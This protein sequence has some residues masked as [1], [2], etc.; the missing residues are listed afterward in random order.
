MN[1]FFVPPSAL[2]SDSVVFSGDQLHQLTRVLRL[3]AGDRV[4]VLTGDGY[5]SEVLLESVDRQ[6]AVGRVLSRSLNA[7]EPRLEVI[8]VQGL[9]KGDKMDLIV[10]K[11][12]E[13]GVA[14]FWPVRT[15]RA[16]VQL[17]EP[18]A[19]QRQTRWQAIAREA[20]EQSRR[21][22]I[23]VVLPVGTLT[24]AIAEAGRAAADR[25]GQVLA[26]FPW[27]EAAASSGAVAS[28]GAGDAPGGM[29]LADVV[30]GGTGLA[31]ALQAA[32]PATVS[33]V[34]L[35]IGPE[36]GFSRAEAALAR[37]AG[38][39]PVSLG[40]RILRTETAGL[41]AVTVVLFALDDLGR[42]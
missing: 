32:D 9:P 6:Q 23:P 3:G 39:R 21:G 33:Q 8:L 29:G 2:R 26:L 17:D 22:R 5:E 16:V 10:Q 34:W 41:A 37:Q 30:P 35:F 36:G 7:A 20:A 42:A 12:T 11:C 28:T 40:P 25:P 18:R 1:R 14:R 13:L 27:E 4:M 19:A 38:V 15:E 24:E 31:D